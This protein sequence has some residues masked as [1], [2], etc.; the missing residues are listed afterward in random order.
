MPKHFIKIIAYNN[1]SSVNWV[2]RDAVRFCFGPLIQREL[3][4]FVNE[5]NHHRIRKS[6]MA[7]CPGGIPELLYRLPQQYGTHCTSIYSD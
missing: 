5:W 4:E 3:D 2:H 6:K 1:M 7:E